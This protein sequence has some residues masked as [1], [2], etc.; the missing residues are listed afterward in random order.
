MSLSQR[1]ILLLQLCEQPDILNGDDRLV[2]EGLDERDLL[3]GERLDLASAHHDHS[4]GN[5]LP[6]EWHTQ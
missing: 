4:D 2:T 1:T 6:H 5:V 3:V